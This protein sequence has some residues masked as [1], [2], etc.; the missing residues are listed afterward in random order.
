M[1]RVGSM[2][3]SRATQNVTM[4]RSE[5]SSGCGASGGRRPW[6]GV[7]GGEGASRLRL[8]SPT[9]QRRSTFSGRREGFR[10]QA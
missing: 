1:L 7:A 5:V 9:L 3:V 10:V 6:N 8:L 2:L 4:V